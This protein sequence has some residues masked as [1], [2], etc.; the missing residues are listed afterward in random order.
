MRVVDYI[1]EHKSGIISGGKG[2]SQRHERGWDSPNGTHFFE[3][4]KK[5]KHY[6]NQVSI[7]TILLH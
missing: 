3:K 5:Y 6:T 2:C 1:K 4:K 7:I